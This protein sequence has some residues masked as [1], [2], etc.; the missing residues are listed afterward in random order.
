LGLPAPRKECSTRRPKKKRRT[1][2]YPMRDK[3]EE[4]C[5]FCCLHERP[6]TKTMRKSTGRRPFIRGKGK[7]GEPWGEVTKGSVPQRLNREE[8][9]KIRPRKRRCARRNRKIKKGIRAGRRER[10]KRPSNTRRK[11]GRPTGGDLLSFNGGPLALRGGGGE[12]ENSFSFAGKRVGA[13]IN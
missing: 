13:P 6:N 7:G 4:G 12:G 2:M 9:K 11:R 1:L 10:K 8:R 3:E 5:C